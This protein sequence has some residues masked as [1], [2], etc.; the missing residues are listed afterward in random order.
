M[1]NVA[2]AVILIV[3]YLLC[4]LTGIVLSQG[5]LWKE[6]RRFTLTVLRDMGMGK[7]TIE[8]RIQEEAL[9]LVEELKKTNGA[10]FLYH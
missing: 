5:D 9:C 2:V 3:F 4:V 8:N 7:K 10:Y 1:A 6:T